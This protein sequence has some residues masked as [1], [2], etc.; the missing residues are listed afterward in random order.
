[1]DI[2]IS[3]TL[4]CLL[5]PL[6]IFISYRIYKKEGR[7]IFCQDWFL[8]KNNQKFLLWRFRTMAKPSR[9]IRAL[10]PYPYPLPD[11]WKYGM[12]NEF[13]SEQ[14]SSITL[15][16]TGEWLKR[17]RLHRIP[18]LWNILKGEMSIIGPEVGIEKGDYCDIYQMNRL[19]LR[20]GLFGYAQLTKESEKAQWEKTKLDL[21]YV[22][23]CSLREDLRIIIKTLNNI[24]KDS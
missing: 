10:P 1:M 3:S 15:T 8:G 16:L 13:T 4:L 24:R 7:P 2:V 9:V 21:H 17:Y 18:Q 5:S 11:S 19:K 22:T 20:P 12:P 6:I 14:D 23:N